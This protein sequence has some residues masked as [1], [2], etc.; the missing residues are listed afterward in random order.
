MPLLHK[1]EIEVRKLLKGIHLDFLDLK[2]VRETDFFSIDLKNNAIPL[3]KTYIGV[4]ANHT[5]REIIDNLGEKDGD[6]QLFFTNCKTFLIELV[7]Q[8][9]KRF[10]DCRNFKFLSC[11]S[12]KVAY[13]L[14]IPSFS[15]IYESL[16]YLTEV[17]DLEVVDQEWRGHAMNPSLNDEMQCSE[18]WRVAFE[19][20]NSGGGKINPN[21][22]KRSLVCYYHFSSLML[23][24]KGFL[25][26]CR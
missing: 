20:K 18:Y 4:K 22:A 1:L 24:L 11:L 7:A 16:A 12:P 9:K 26:S 3:V 8:I 5:M 6:V 21:L 13:N 19:D 2:Y 10:E 14:S 15:E 17:A 23:Q 25:V